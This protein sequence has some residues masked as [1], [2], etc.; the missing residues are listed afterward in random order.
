MSRNRGESMI[1]PEPAA[2]MSSRRLAVMKERAAQ[3]AKNKE[4]SESFNQ[5]MEAMKAQQFQTAVDAF[6]KALGGN[7]QTLA[8]LREAIREDIIKGKERERQALLENQAQDQLIAK[9]PFEVPPSLIQEE[10][11][12]LFREQWERYSQY[13][14]NPAQMD[15]TKLLEALK[16][17]A[18]RRARA[19]II[20]GRIAGQEGITVDDAEADATLARIAVHSGRDVNEVRKLYQERNLMD[21]LKQQLRDEKIMKM[22]LDKANISTNPPAAPEADE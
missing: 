3:L 13:G 1:T 21:V 2:Q 5:G 12:N 10:Q 22:L 14:L 15:H 17:M 18:E 6:A 20:L 11:E 9:H 7:F 8:D 19:K 16:P 4:L